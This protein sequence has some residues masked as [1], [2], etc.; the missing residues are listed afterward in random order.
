MNTFLEHC[1]KSLHSIK[2]INLVNIVIGNPSCDLDSAVSAIVYAY[3]IFKK[4]KELVIPVLNIPSNEYFLKTEVKF[5]LK[6]Y[7]IADENLVFNDQVDLSGWCCSQKLKLH[8]VDH[9]ELTTKSLNLEPCVTSVI[10]HRPIAKN[11]NNIYTNINMVGSCSTLIAQEILKN[12]PEILTTEIISLLHAVIVL[13]TIN[14][15][16]EAKRFTQLDI[17]ILSELKSRTD[18]VLDDEQIFNELVEARKSIS[19]FTSLQLLYKDL[20]IV[21]NV[22][23]PGF[24]L[25]VADFVKRGDSEDALETFCKENSCDV[26]VLMGLVTKGTA[27]TRDIG[28]YWASVNSQPLADALIVALKGNLAPNLELEESSCGLNGFSLFKQGNVTAT[29]KA[30]LPIVNQIISS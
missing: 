14:F 22:A 18:I 24:P 12:L 10:D 26:A 3:Y 25:L 28:V 17:D 6:K 19:G 8:L 9:H 5:L 30:I 2:T 16:K 13:D 15:S 27:V 1:K 7:K 23:I 21:K 20:K 29:R 4:N 11:W